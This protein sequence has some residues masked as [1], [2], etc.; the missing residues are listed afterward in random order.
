MKKILL[1]LLLTL[2]GLSLIANPVDPDK[3]IQV[4]KRFAMLQVK[5]TDSSA[6]IVYT[7]TM[8]NSG[9]PAIYAVNV[10]GSAFVL[11]AADDIAHPVL[12]YSMSRPWPT[13]SADGSSA[14]P[15][16]EQM[17]LPSQVTAFLDDL[18][19][20]IEAARQQAIAPDR[21][22]ASE[23]SI[24]LSGSSPMLGEGDPQGGGVCQT[25]SSSL[26][27]SVGPLLTTT[28]DQ[29]QYYN[30]LC[31]ED[32]NGPD[33]H[34]W[35][36]CVA[37]A[38]AQIINYWG[39]P[40]HGRGIHSYQS[41]YGTLTVNY[42]SANYD[43]AHMPDALTSTSTPQEV[44]AVA[45]LM[46]DCGV[47]ANMLYSASES[48]AFAAD[49]RGG[50]IN[51]F[52][53]SPN[54]SYAQKYF[55]S[56]SEW[57]SLLIENIG[58]GSPVYVNTSNHALV[59]DGYNEN[60]FFHFN[61]GWSG[62][63]DGWYLMSA[64]N[65][66]GGILYMSSFGALLGITPD[67]TGNIIL[68][69]SNGTSFFVVNCPMEFYSSMGHNY[70][71]NMDYT[72]NCQN[73]I[74]FSFTDT[75]QRAVVDIIRYE[76][77]S[78]RF[79]D[80]FQGNQW[81]NTSTTD[82]G[83]IIMSGNSFSFDYYGYLNDRGFAI[84]IRQED[85]CQ[86]PMVNIIRDTTSISIDYTN[87]DTSVLWQI[88]YGLS[89]FVQGEG[90]I[91]NVTSNVT[92]I[93]NLTRYSAYDIYIRSVCGTDL[94]SPWVKYNIVLDP[95]WTD[96]VIS[97]PSG[98]V[99]DANGNVEISSAEGLAW[100]SVL[101]NGFHGHQ[102][103]SF[104]GK[105]VTLVADINLE[106]YRWYPMGRYLNWAWTKFS[107]TF[108]GQ[109]HT[110][111]N[112]YVRDASSNLGLF[113]RV[114]R[115]R[116]KNVSM[117]GG[118]VSSTLEPVG[119]DPQYWLP[120]STIGGLVG[121]T[122]ECYE[123]TNCHSSV[124]VYGNGGAGSLC[125]Y[126]WAY[127]ENITTIVS[128]C[129]SSGDVYGRDVCGGLIGG[130][131]GDVFIRNCFSTGNVYITSCEFDAWEQG[132]GGL[133]GSF[134]S[135]PTI[136]NCFST[137][138]VYNE[139][140][141]N[142]PIGK[143][144]GYH[145][146]NAHMR[147]VYGRDDI[148]QELGLFGECNY[149]IS[150]TF[151]A[152]TAQFH[153]NGNAD[154]LTK[155][156]NIAGFLYDNLNEVLNAW[157][158]L[159]N[160]PDLKT[161]IYDSISGFPIFGDNFVPSCYNPTDLVA[162]NA[163]IVGDTIIRTELSWTQ[164]GNPDHWEIL[165]VASEQSPDS[166]VIVSVNSNPYVLTGIP[167]GH[168]LDFYVRAICDENDTSGWSSLVTYIPDKLR[169][170]EVVTSQP[171]GYLED[172]SGNIFIST[173]EGLAWL[174]SV[175]NGLNGIPYN[176]NRFYNKRVELVA[177]IDISE[178]RWTSI[179]KDWTY[180]CNDISFNGN[181][182]S[183]SGLYC[184]ELED[185]QG[186][187]GYFRNGTV[188][189]VS[190][191]DCNVFGENTT[192]LL[193]G[194]ALG[195]NILN[196]SA[197]GNVY[198]IDNVGGLVGIHESGEI[199]YIKNCYFIG[200]V[201]ARRDITKTNTNVGSIGGIVGTPFYDSIINC[202]VVGEIANDCLWP[203]IVTGTGGRPHLVSNCYHKANDALMAITSNNCVI[204]PSNNSSFSGYD[205]VWVLNT[206]ITIEG[207]TYSNLISA[208]NAWVD[209][210][211]TDGQY[212]RWA[213]DTAN[214]NGGF[215]LFAAIPCPVIDIHD[216]I[217]AC[218]SY[219]WNGDSYT[220]SA[221]VTDTLYAFNGC[222]SI[223]TLHLTINNPVH[224]ATIETACDSYTWNNTT[225]TASGNY[226]YSHADANGC[227][228]VDTLHLT[229][230]NPEHYA[231]TAAA[232]NTYTWN[233][234]TYTASGNYTHSHLDANGCTQV[235]T[236]HLT[237][238][239]PVHTAVTEA[240]CD[241]YTWNNTTYT[242][243]GNY[244]FSHLD[245]NGCT[246]VD[247]L[248]LTVNNPVHTATT[249]T[250]CESYTW[251]NTAYITSGNYTFSHL[252]ANGCTQVDTLHL[253]INNPVHTATTE[254]ACES[255]TWNNTAYTTSGNYTF[256]HLDANG[257]TQVD[258]LHLTI[259]NLVHIST[260]ETAC[261]TYTWNNTAYTTSGN[262]TFSHLDANGCTQVDTLHLTINNPVH[263]TT[264]ETACESYTWNSTTYTTGGNYTFSHLD[265][266][267]CTQVDTLHLTINNPV[268]TA[269][270]E[271]ACES[272]TWN[273]TAYTASGNYTYSHLDA[274]G[275]T[276]VDT[277][278]LT[279]N[280]STTGDTTAVAC[281]SFT[282]W[283]TNYTNSTNTPTHTYTNVAGCD[284]VVTL[285]LTINYSVETTVSE[286]AE[287]SYTWNGETYTESG[288]Y[289]WHGTTVDGCDSTVTLML[290]INTVGID[291]I[292]NSKFEIDIY[293]NPT[294]GMLTIEGDGVVRVE[295]MD[296]LGRVT[297]DRT[298]SQWEGTLTIDLSNMPQGSYV[299]RIITCD[300]SII[301][302]VMKR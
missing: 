163:T 55:Y 21:N 112:I 122:N 119:F 183:I 101:V 125:G 295:V 70:Y 130:V 128:N 291:E 102:P 177:D 249:E 105:T 120:S 208:L 260:T 107:G 86:I 256:S 89:D 169:W 52:Q 73:R 206:P 135:N 20:Q 90:T 39:Y 297:M 251:N 134:R 272:Y 233:N 194:Y 44:N 82:F 99:E 4:A 129:S 143:T 136:N 146:Q 85:N 81:I 172:E 179:G 277:L 154:T 162:S 2:M 181:N 302:R 3:A 32:A 151:I 147:Y 27:D 168:P 62:Y 58:S 123:I 92:T 38:M 266:N 232:C 214:V 191:N 124:N 66:D 65:D 261:E 94:Y 141:Y 231:T 30:A 139:V 33:G 137:G 212:R 243:S 180:S 282:W 1:S 175:V 262:Y 26:P 12:G 97:Q 29:G 115:G 300:G 236:L 284:S 235:D 207:I 149:G 279:I 118:S 9:S 268:H 111:S 227:T 239:N 142:R 87:Y 238:N 188:S 176:N 100:L 241:S 88:E 64:V 157:V 5:I 267:G 35:T 292:E 170:T 155:T 16:G 43:Y 224:T 34:V 127:E 68:G 47:A 84:Y 31:P 10:G 205:T 23:W 218:E 63:S 164:I 138:L 199:T 126:I 259:N 15:R 228:Q 46:R 51:F 244:T 57:D 195:I 250:A 219:T 211:N 25:P 190:L 40:I 75:T 49:A 287:G 54:L 192:G 77:Q 6:A 182:H 45:T 80:V 289:Q 273:N 184:N 275:C 131:Y 159:Q 37:T 61:Y 230:N 264:T 242:A 165:Y 196:C 286:T 189:N 200:T 213:T 274:N 240:A 161:W 108:D 263:T 223:V 254:T 258:T 298:L 220:S 24:Y 290:T 203:G 173:A 294:T 245:A 248:H 210:N 152:D 59:C 150:N 281:D 226:T 187:F 145:D 255:F 109:N 28:W 160:N 252:D 114:E 69:Q 148:N 225:Y 18:A 247:T 83:S 67:S 95:Y 167:V 96:V 299:L 121:E 253:T 217:T 276:Q 79:Y 234:T 271:T 270:T 246:Q 56:D 202:Y 201:A 158:T 197:S 106:G 153:N 283:N 193:I 116:L 98:Y 288:T 269:T 178:Y 293:P 91:I 110:I 78:L 53:F 198:G 156:I 50:F 13:G 36:G 280:Y 174:S 74:T 221:I 204:A 296:M 48:G 140:N 71:L 209:A 42:D 19:S 222:D 166:G 144:I 7:H 60:G 72:N 285:H 133:I 14:F 301:R 257:C 8:P 185:Y 229:I 76:G 41:D 215:P 278:H 186:L 104:E 11:V 93:N 117:V 132:R 22:I 237:I 171:E 17:V 113:G 265:A 216:T 103:N